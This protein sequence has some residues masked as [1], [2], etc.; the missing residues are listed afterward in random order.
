M[1]EIVTLREKLTQDLAFQDAELVRRTAELEQLR[2]A[3]AY[4]ASLLAQ[5]RSEVVPQ[6][7]DPA[8]P[9]AV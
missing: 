3:R 1:A 8:E 6:A 9:V 4:T 2:G 7:A 5:L